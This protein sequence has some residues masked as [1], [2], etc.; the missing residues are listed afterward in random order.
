M[1]DLNNINPRNDSV[2]HIRI[3]GKGSTLLGRQLVLDYVRPFYHPKYGRF[4]S[5]SG[6]IAWYKL[7][8][9]D[10]HIRTLTGHDLRQYVKKQIEE[11]KNTYRSKFIEDRVFESLIYYSILS[12]SDLM[13]LFSTNKLPFVVYFLTEN[14][15]VRMKDK[16]YSK[17]LNG[18]R[19]KLPN[20][21]NH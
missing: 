15:E 17:L 14:N 19:A 12:K 4:E 11:E 18:V 7:E 1:A 16:Q 5:L 10:D 20:L 13:E 6:A 9:E 8:K 2:D 21:I 3:D